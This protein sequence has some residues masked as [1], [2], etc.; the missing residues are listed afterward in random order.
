M[1]TDKVFQSSGC[2]TW[3][4]TG[5]VAPTKDTSYTDNNGG[6]SD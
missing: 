5:D 1:P 3:H 2:G 4:R 6:T